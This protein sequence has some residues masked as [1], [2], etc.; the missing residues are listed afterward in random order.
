MI[1]YFEIFS[2]LFYC[3]KTVNWKVFLKALYITTIAYLYK[4][5]ITYYENLV[6]KRGSAI[7]VLLSFMT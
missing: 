7:P 2:V 5:M 4:V 1:R 3:Q 6:S